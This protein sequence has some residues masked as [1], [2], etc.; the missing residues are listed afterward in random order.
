MTSLREFYASLVGLVR[1]GYTSRSA[2]DL[3]IVKP[4]QVQGEFS[5]PIVR[6]ILR[7]TATSTV[8]RATVTEIIAPVV[9]TSSIPGTIIVVSAFVES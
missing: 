6:V 2:A 1:C 3:P 7:V 8:V 9:Y 5:V 4:I